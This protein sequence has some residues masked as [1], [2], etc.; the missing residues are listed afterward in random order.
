MP[1]AISR[2]EP[3][4]VVGAVVADDADQQVDD[5]AADEQQRQLGAPQPA[6]HE[7]RERGDDEQPGADRAGEAPAQRRRVRVVGRQEGEAGEVEEDAEAAGEGEDHERDADRE[8][9]DAEV[10]ADPAGDAADQ[11]VVARAGQPR[12]RRRRAVGCSSVGGVSV[13]AVT[14]PCADAPPTIGNHPEATL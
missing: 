1:I 8:R 10:A 6:G 4:D 12:A 9:V 3:A 5:D 2:R 14:V 11:A 13:M 7:D